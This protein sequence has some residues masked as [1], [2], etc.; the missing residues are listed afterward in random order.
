MDIE[1]NI[2]IVTKIRMCNLTPRFYNV[3]AYTFTFNEL[4]GF[5]LSHSSLFGFIIYISLSKL[6]PKNTS[7]TISPASSVGTYFFDS[8]F[9]SL[10]TSCVTISLQSNSPKE[11][12]EKFTCLYIKVNCDSYRA[13][14]SEPTGF[15]STTLLKQV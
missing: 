9:S 2:V 14:S 5:V 11:Y 6:P 12:C 13:S 1:L 10:M 4:R 15:L 7:S 8:S 3:C